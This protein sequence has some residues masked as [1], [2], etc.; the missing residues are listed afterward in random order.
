MTRESPTDFVEITAAGP[1]RAATQNWADRE[2]LALDTEFI[3]DDSYYPK[4]C[5]IQVGDGRDNACIDAIALDAAAMQPLFAMLAQP[6]I[7]KVFHAASQ[8]L[9]IFVQLTGDCPRPLFDTQLAAS[10]LGDGDQLGYAGLVEKRLGIKLD[11]SLTRTDWSRRPLTQAELAY[12]AADVQHLAELYPRLLEELIARNRLSWLVED[13]ARLTDPLRYRNPPEDAW[14]RLKGI[15]RLGASAQR[16]AA[17]LA[18]WREA[19]A[20]Q[21]NRPRK[22]ILDD[23]PLYRL[24]ERKPESEEQLADLKVLPPKTLSRHGPAL[25][26]VIA[27]ARHDAHP[28][29]VEEPPLIDTQKAKLQKLQE[30]LRQRAGTLNIPASLLAPRADLEGIVRRGAEAGVP[31]L[32]GWRRDVAGAEMLALL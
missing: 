6:S 28:L 17:E 14:R 1:L 25:L 4:P 2:W 19:V 11:K 16:V 3:R 18:G 30:W 23:E 22:W 9:E 32:E 21:R 15:A 12:A 8:D 27:R 10:L 7:T 24:A 20:Q 29:A 31:L 26:E 13:C 5:L